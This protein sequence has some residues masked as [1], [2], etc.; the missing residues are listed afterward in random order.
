MTYPSA[1]LAQLFLFFLFS[2]SSSGYFWSVSLVMLYLIIVVT[3]IHLRWFATMC[4]TVH[5]EYLISTFAKT[6]SR[7][8]GPYSWMHA[9]WPIV[10]QINVSYR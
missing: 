3:H 4:G 2:P 7:H 8:M 5:S 1:S 10:S 9:F 6:T